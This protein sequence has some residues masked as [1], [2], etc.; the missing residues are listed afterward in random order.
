MKEKEYAQATEL[1]N[2][3]VSYS[4]NAHNSYLTQT[5]LG[6]I[7]DRIK[8]DPELERIVEAIRSE[9]DKDKRRKLKEDNLPY[10]VLGT[11]ENDHRKSS[12]LI[13][14]QF[15]SI[16]FDD[17]DGRAD[18]LDEK[19]KADENVFTYFKSPSNNRME[20]NILCYTSISVENDKCI[21]LWLIK[22]FENSDFES[23]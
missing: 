9:P 19:L 7:F 2:I 13:S 11:F 8:E 22:V 16:D 21:H 20:N 17:L 1:D 15:I 4:H 18:E 23:I 14:T 12:N 10:F 6:D 5:N 3:T